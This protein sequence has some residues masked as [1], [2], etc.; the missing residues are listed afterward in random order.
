MQINRFPGNPL[1][2]PADLKPSEPD[3]VVE[4]VLNPGA[5][6]YRDRIGLVLRVAEKPRTDDRTAVAVWRDPERGYVQL[7]VDRDD[8]ELDFSDPRVF[9]YRNRCYLSTISH[10]LVAWSDDGGR[11]FVPDYSLRLFP[12]TTHET[13]GI[14][15]C[16]VQE[17]DGVYHLTYTAVSEFGVAGGHCTTTDWKHFSERDLILPPHNKD[18]ALFPRRVNGL[19]YCFHRPSGLGLGG[20]F[21]WLAESPDLRHWGN[22]RCV[23]VTRP[24]S[25]DS[26]RLGAGCAP[27]ETPEG[28][29]ELYHG[30]DG[31]SYRLGLMLFDRND[32]AK[33]LARSTE[34]IM[35]PIEGVE[36]NGFYGNCIFTN[37]QV[38]DGDRILMYYGAAD[39]VVCGAELSLRELLASLR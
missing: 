7:R 11:T 23:A 3:F 37:G 33:L 1:L 19:Y 21:L 36:T 24:G 10:L 38:L 14:E 4:C 31:K 34:P 22:H 16:R 12:A 25:W 2:R 26:E 8:P 5:F 17:I 20:N 32:P 9:T 28:W 35:S 18:I 39:T 13:Y 15:D 30:S 6:R 29:L 27:I